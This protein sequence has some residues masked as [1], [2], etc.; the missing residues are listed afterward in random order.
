M[1]DAVSEELEKTEPTPSDEDELSTTPPNP[2]LETEDDTGWKMPKP[3]FR[4]TSGY[5]P[6]GFAKKDSQD[7]I[8]PNVDDD[9][10]TAAT[11]KPADMT[12]VEPQPDLHESDPGFHVP[13]AAPEKPVKKRGAMNALLTIFLLLIT[14]GII[15]AFLAVVYFLF[16]APSS[17]TN[18]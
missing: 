13:A 15:V 2:A 3:V 5:L 11:E 8:A 17:D 12:D 7:E 1:K 4:K 6:Q 9:I 10:S 16:L 14:L 18:F